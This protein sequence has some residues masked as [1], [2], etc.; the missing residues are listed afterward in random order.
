MKFVPKGGIE[1]SQ[2]NFL[3]HWSNVRSEGTYRCQSGEWLPRVSQRRSVS[4][5]DP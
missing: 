5:V 4:I 3:F 2:Y 1:D